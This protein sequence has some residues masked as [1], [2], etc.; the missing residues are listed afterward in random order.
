[1]LEYLEKNK[2]KLV[3]F[4]LIVYWLILLTAT[5][6]PS[7]EMPDIHMSDKIEH[8]LGYGVLT[9]LITFSLLVQ[10]K[11]KLLK[12]KA[13][14]ATI[15]I[16]SVYGA[17]D[18]LHQMF[19]PGRDCDFYDWVTDFAAAFFGIIIVYSLVK[20]VRFKVRNF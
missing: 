12:A 6:L 14:L 2:L 1:M 15:I 20:F 9:I 13:Y 11:N 19:V 17:L 10:S 3:Y 4:P 7:N 8:F 18:E 5:S 16:V